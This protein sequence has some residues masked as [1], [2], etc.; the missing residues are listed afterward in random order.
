[1]LRYPLGWGDY[2]NKQV[3]QD[4][5]KIKGYKS[6]T[7][8]QLYFYTLEKQ[9]KNEIEKIIQEEKKKTIPFSIA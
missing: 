8:N 2:K 5:R 9:S 3:Q 7:Q 4:Y 6:N 1:M